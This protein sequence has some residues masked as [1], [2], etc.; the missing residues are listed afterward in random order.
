MRARPDASGVRAGSPTEDSTTAAATRTTTAAT[1]QTMLG[2]QPRPAIA[3]RPIDSCDD[4]SF[5][6]FR[7]TLRALVPRG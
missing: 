6:L 7:R 5:L 2:A 3:S 4:E 1:P